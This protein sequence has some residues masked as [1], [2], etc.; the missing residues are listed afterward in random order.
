MV[1]SRRRSDAARSAASLLT[2]MIS[3]AVNAAP[4]P[5]TASSQTG[6]ELSAREASNNPVANSAGLRYLISLIVFLALY[7]LINMTFQMLASASDKTAAA[8]PA[9]SGYRQQAASAA[10]RV[11]D[12]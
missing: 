3:S 10:R 8:L 12:E 6:P 11:G 2:E 4:L 7:I 1:T 5:K 9:H